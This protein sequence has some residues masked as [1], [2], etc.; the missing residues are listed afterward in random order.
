MPA[1]EENKDNFKVTVQMMHSEARCF[2]LTLS[3]YMGVHRNFSMG[4][5]EGHV[6]K[7]MKSTVEDCQ[8]LLDYR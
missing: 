2:E 6:T 3:M 4:A 1:L 8:A 7:E 5:K